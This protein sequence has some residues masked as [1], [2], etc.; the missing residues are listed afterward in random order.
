[1]MDINCDLGEGE[2]VEKTRRLLRWLTSA[3]IACG[4]HAGSM[5][6]R[7]VFGCASSVV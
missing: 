3:N 5:R 1:M 6:T 7:S 4:G 2:P